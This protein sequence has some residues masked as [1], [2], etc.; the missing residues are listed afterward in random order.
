MNGRIKVYNNYDEF[1][2]HSKYNS[3]L[4]FRI[5]FGFIFP[6]FLLVVAEIDFFFDFGIL[7]F[8]IIP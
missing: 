7:L 2:G 1:Y 6:I 4:Y 5:I 8:F 3:L